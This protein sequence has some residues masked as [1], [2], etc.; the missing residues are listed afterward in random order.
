MVAGPARA[1]SRL[2][3]VSRTTPRGAH[4][5]GRDGGRARFDIK[6]REY[7]RATGSPPVVATVSQRYRNRPATVAYESGRRYGRCTGRQRW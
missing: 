7:S 3:V 2:R 5:G 6:A 4:P 1:A